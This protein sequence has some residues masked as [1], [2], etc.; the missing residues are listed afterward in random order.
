[1]TLAGSS[2]PR[3]VPF[4]DVVCDALER[5]VADRRSRIHSDG[6]NALFLWDQGTRLPAEL[7]RAVM[8][9]GR[10]G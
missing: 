3:D 5:Y 2:E 9:A 7:A 8:R 4:D 10:S 6:L 1:M